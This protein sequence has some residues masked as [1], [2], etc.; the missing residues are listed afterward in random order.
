MTRVRWFLAALALSVA[1]PSFAQ[2][3]DPSNVTTVQVVTMPD[4]PLTFKLSSDLSLHLNVSVVAFS[5]NL[6]AKSYEG[7]APLTALYALTS[8]RLLDGGVVV[9]GSVAFDTDSKPF[10]EFNAGIVSPRLT[11]SPS[12]SVHAAVLYARRFGPDPASYVRLAPTL[13]F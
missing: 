11:L 13:E 7:K 3:A 1:L 5:Y 10:G 6:T 9:G 12:L 2:S 4:V 8:K